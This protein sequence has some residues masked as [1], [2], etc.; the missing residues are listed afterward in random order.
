MSETDGPEDPEVAQLR[1]QLEA[2][3]RAAELR[4]QREAAQ[5][6]LTAIDDQIE[7]LERSA[8]GKS[9]S[10]ETQL[11]EETRA[12]RMD[13]SSRS[14]ASGRNEKRPLTSAEA[15]RRWE[16]ELA[17]ARHEGRVPNNELRLNPQQRS[18]IKKNKYK[19]NRL[20][21]I[22]AVSLAAVVVL[23]LVVETPPPRT[24]A[25]NYGEP[26]SDNG[27]AF[28]SSNGDWKEEVPSATTKPAKASTQVTESAPKSASDD[29]R[30]QET[31]WI[32]QQLAKVGPSVEMFDMRVPKADV[33]CW[34]EKLVR[35]RGI[36]YLEN[37]PTFLSGNFSA[38][39]ASFF[40]KTASSC[41]DMLTS[42]KTAF[43]QEGFTSA[44]VDCIFTG[45][46]QN[47]LIDWWIEFYVSG[48]EAMQLKML[49]RITPAKI[50]RCLQ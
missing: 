13:A 24:V 14:G 49:E 35:G 23:A 46:D 44:Q 28:A 11:G 47:M 9:I 26:P 18:E 1:K 21:L 37:N 36:D 20:W 29:R 50:K 8:T 34:I 10:E 45:I 41:I 40:I 4:A 32:D 15:Q 43:R 12:E 31:R 17:E 7:A 38:S 33:R 5:D 6:E 19:Q 16:R 30:S 27:S 48:P 25:E 2:A 42:Q 39:D 3:E 22:G